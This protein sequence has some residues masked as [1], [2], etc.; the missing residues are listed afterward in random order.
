ML[1]GTRIDVNQVLAGTYVL[2]SD[3]TVNAPALLKIEAGSMLHA[4]RSG[5]RIVIN[6][7][8]QLFAQGTREQPIILAGMPAT[9][10]DPTSIDLSVG[11]SSAPDELSVPAHPPPRQPTPSTN[12]YPQWPNRLP[13]QRHHCLSGIGTCAS[14][15]QGRP[16]VHVWDARHLLV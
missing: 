12:S 10:A 5:I 14:A 4:N 9:L 13:P 3:I 8:A 16:Q 7:G 15:W 2:N 6:E 1:L 11:T